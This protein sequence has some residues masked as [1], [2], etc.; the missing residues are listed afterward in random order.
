[1]VIR[2]GSTM[3]IW[4]SGRAVCDHAGG[5]VLERPCVGE[6]CWVHKICQT[7]YFTVTA[8]VTVS[9]QGPGP[10]ARG[11]WPRAQGPGPMARGPGP[12]APR[13]GPN[14][15]R[16]FK[17][18][19]CARILI[20]GARFPPFG[21]AIA[22]ISSNSNEDVSLCRKDLL[23]PDSDRGRSVSPLRVRYSGDKL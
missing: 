21:F 9:A 15:H 11:P 20:E 8:Q 1:M 18:T 17:T 13:P 23:W 2:T 6:V 3:R 4:Q 14:V 16:F 22:A 5:S 7:V 12:K 19:Y 10:M